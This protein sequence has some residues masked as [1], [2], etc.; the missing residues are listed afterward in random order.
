M[1]VENEIQSAKTNGTI[2]PLT[3]CFGGRTALFHAYIAC[4]T[5]NFQ[6]G[7]DINQTISPKLKLIWLSNSDDFKQESDLNHDLDST[8]GN[9]LWIVDN[10]FVCWNGIC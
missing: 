3:V 10:Q 7:D 2:A 1:V 6:P 4:G 8:N 5:V 9:N